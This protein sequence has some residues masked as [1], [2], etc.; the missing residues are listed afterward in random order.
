MTLAAVWGAFSNAMVGAFSFSMNAGVECV[1][2]DAGHCDRDGRAPPNMAYY[3]PKKRFMNSICNSFGKFSHRE[4]KAVGGVKTPLCLPLSLSLSPLLR[5]GAR[6]LE[7]A[8][9]FGSVRM[10]PQYCLA[11]KE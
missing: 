4:E 1:R 8:A 3:T 2:R 6:G 5:R 9:E 7:I 10:R 11:A